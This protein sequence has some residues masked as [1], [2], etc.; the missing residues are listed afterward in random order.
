MTVKRVLIIGCSGVA[1]FFG[2]AV[3]ALGALFWHVAQDPEGV[4]VSVENPLTVGL[5]EEFTLA[6]VVHNEREDRAFELSDIDIGEAY[7]EGFLIVAT[8]PRFKSS[9]HVPIDDT[10]SFA[11]NVAI[12]PRE[13]RRFEFRL[14]PAQVGV[15]RGDVDI[16]EGTQFLTTVAQTAVEQSGNRPDVSVP[17]QER[18]AAGAV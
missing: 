11:F 16:C 4:S 1:L 2:V 5:G 17:A 8:E 13:S 6:V 9:M 7:L 10:R 3:V 14:R 15:W 12:P 18:S